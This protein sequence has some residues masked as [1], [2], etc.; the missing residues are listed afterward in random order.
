MKCP[1]CEV[2]LTSH[3]NGILVCH[4]CGHTIS[5]PKQCP[6][7]GSHYMAAFGIGTQKVETMV[8]KEFSNAKVLRMDLDTTKAK[9]GHEKILTSFAN[10]EA[11]IL[12]GTQ[13]IVK[14]HDFPNVTLVG[15]LAADLS[16]FS[17]D[18]HASERT[19]QLLTQ[20]VGRAGRSSLKGDA[21][22][23]TYQPE[24]Y[25]IITAAKQDYENFYHQE[26]LYRNLLGYPPVYEMLSVHVFSKSPEEAKRLA[27]WIGNFVETLP[28]KTDLQ[29]IGPADAQIS[30]VKDIYHKIIHLKH[31]NH[32]ILVSIKN[33]IER[34]MKEE[35]LL[36]KATVQFDFN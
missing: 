10:G 1:H 26:I 13:M 29:K 35:G 14:G 30:K 9:G 8:K 32:D 36:K 3:L 15:V 27:E 4:Y 19:F 16:L 31:K 33:K 22:I 21:V 12:I 28:D 20:A 5:M 18:Y 6:A 23:Q 24:H 11:D 7:C 2:S 25:G 17:G 34:L